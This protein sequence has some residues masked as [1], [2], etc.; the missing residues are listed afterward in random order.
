MKKLPLV[1]L[2]I[3]L[4]TEEYSDSDT[5]EPWSLQLPTRAVCPGGG[6]RKQQK[7]QAAGHRG[8]ERRQARKRSQLVCTS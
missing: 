2:P 6:Q 4:P 3:K 8:L 7:P 1:R 5:S